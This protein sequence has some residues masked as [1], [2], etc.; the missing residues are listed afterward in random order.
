MSDESE[1]ALLAAAAAG[2]REAGERL[3]ESTYRQLFA[4]LARLAGG[5]ADLAADLTQETY[6]KAWQNLAS[7]RGGAAFSTWLYRIGYT[8]FLNQIRRPRRTV[9]I[10]DAAPPVDPAPDGEI[11][12]AERELRRRLRA[13]VLALDDD[14]RFTVTARYWA[15]LPVAEIATL[16]GITPVAVRKRLARANVRLHA[17]LEESHS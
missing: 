4:S 15:E 2:D 3:V 10:D 16:E 13:A 5:D 1:S 8:T 14:L 9:P 12:A 17:A 6:R 11:A 7:F